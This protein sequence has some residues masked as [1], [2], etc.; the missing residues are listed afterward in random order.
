MSAIPYIACA[1]FTASLG[2]F[3]D[4]LIRNNIL[5]RRNLRR[6]FN[7]IGL[8]IPAVFVIALSFVTCSLPYLGVAFLTIGLAFKYC[9]MF[10]CYRIGK[11]FIKFKTFKFKKNP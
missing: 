5:T 10:Y 8:F 6:I 7:F 4:I 11:I 9:K 3:S 2:I 1:T